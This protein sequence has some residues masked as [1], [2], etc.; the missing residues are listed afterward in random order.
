MTPRSE[1]EFS[2]GA[3]GA[4]IV[5]QRDAKGHVESLEFR[6]KRAH[7]VEESP[8]PEQMQ[9]YLGEYESV[10][11]GTF[12]RVAS[13]KDSLEL[14]HRR[15]GTIALTQ[16]WRDDFGS[17]V[18]FMSSVE[19]QRDRDGRVIGFIVNGNARSRNIRF[20]KRK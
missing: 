14:Q 18:T 9:E 13:K 16:L 17:P 8:R 2:A 6:G 3:G 19:F 15:H 4:K 20:L 1:R 10:E 11:L 12:Y 7:K 5:F